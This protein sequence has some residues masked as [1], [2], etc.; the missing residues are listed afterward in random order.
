MI[1]ALRQILLDSTEIT[2]VIVDRVYLNNRAQF[3]ALP[4]ILIEKDSAE[5]N[6]VKE[7]TSG[8]DM[9]RVSV[10]C[11]AIDYIHASYLSRAVRSALD[12]YGGNVNISVGTVSGMTDYS[13]AI[14]RLSFSTER[15]DWSDQ[16][17]GLQIITQEYM[18]HVY[19]EGAFTGN[20]PVFVDG[21]WIVFENSAA[22]FPGTGLSNVLYGDTSSGLLYYWDGSAYQTWNS[23]GGG[24]GGTVW[25]DGAGAPSNALGA[26]GDYY[27][28]TTNG[29]VHKKAAGTYSVVGNIKG[30]AGA[31]GTNGTNGSDGADGVDG[32]DGREIELQ[33]TATHVQWRY[34][35]EATWTDLVALSD[36][37]GPAGTNGTNGTNGSD[38][39][40]GSVWYSGSGT[41]SSGLG[42]NGDYYL[43][44]TTWDLSFK[45]SGTWAVIGNIKGATGA[46]GATGPSG[47]SGFTT[48][49]L[50]LG[51]LT[52]P[53]AIRFIRI[54]ANNTV[55]ALSAADM[56]TALGI[57]DTVSFAID[58]NGDTVAAATTT[59]YN[60]Y[61]GQVTDNTT[62]ANRQAV[63][64]FSGTL[65][66]FYVQSTSTQT[67]TGTLVFTVRINGVDTGVSVTIPQSGAAQVRSDTTNT[68][69]VNAGDL[70]SVK[71]VN[72]AAASASCTLKSMAFIIERTY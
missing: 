3:E 60:P 59:Y 7:R 49:G 51:N 6:E 10:S 16:N 17:D 35:G 28:N 71:A 19:R 52:N 30:P 42:I 44:T 72:S 66:N 55:S 67:A 34:A 64:P 1:E 47:T 22:S 5:P 37:T 8:I 65:K 26:N 53:D 31:N 9:Y 14:G 21:N 68:A 48:V 20:P 45:S 4:A 38:G 29:D 36:I 15:D 18:C 61:A 39:A 33:K 57:I 24:G 56:R 63:I 40:P 12:G 23:G 32:A 62:E 50:A 43:N 58:L 2:D 46:T 25:R 13:I 27:L 41:P 70:I 69:T 54:N 11:F